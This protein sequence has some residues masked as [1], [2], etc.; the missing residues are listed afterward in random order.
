MCVITEL[1]YSLVCDAFIKSEMPI[2]GAFT[3]L[4]RFLFVFV[5][6]KRK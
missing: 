2:I 4:Q 6:D 5:E 3:C 1:V